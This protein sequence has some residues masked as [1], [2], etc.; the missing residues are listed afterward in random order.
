MEYYIFA[1]RVE[2]DNCLT[3][4]NNTSWFPIMG[5]VQ[6]RPAPLSQHTTSWAK[7][8]LEMVSGEWAVP[9]IP[10]ARLDYLE[11]PQEDRDAFMT[12]FGQDIRI[13]TIAD[14]PA[15]LIDL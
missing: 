10:T 13:L 5:T 8:S 3:Y 1:T 9:R 2:S 12:F 14:F 4:I 11:V 6:G 7:E 15:E